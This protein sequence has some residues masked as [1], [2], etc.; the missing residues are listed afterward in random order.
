[1]KANAGRLP[2][3]AWRSG[4]PTGRMFGDADAGRAATRRRFP[5]PRLEKLTYA[6]DMSDPRDIGE[7]IRRARQERGLTQDQ[8]AE[9]VGVS[10]SAVAQWE[11]GRAGQLTGNLARIADVLGVG[12][13][14]LTHG[15]NKRAGGQP[16]TGDEM[17][18]LRLY[19]ECRPEDRQLLLR[20]ARRLA[21]R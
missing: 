11:T 3:V 16:G 5:L 13:E 1:M 19:R 18:V 20:M 7:R 4:T 6:N 21:R 12:L 9:E 14:H 2:G 17:A 8:L 15:R 10:R